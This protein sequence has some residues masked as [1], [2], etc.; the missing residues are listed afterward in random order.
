[1]DKIM[2]QPDGLKSMIY[3]WEQVF[4]ELEL[5][6]LMVIRAV[7]AKPQLIIIDRVFDRL[8]T[9]DIELLLFH[10]T[11]LNKTLLITVTQYPNLIPLSNCLVLS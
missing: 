9:K 6:Q 8:A 2:R 4:T 1:M 5:I 7:L 10:L 11:A 3:D